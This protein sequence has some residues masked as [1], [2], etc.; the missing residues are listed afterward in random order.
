MKIIKNFNG[1]IK[2]ELKSPTANIE[3]KI[4]NKIIPFF[5]KWIEGYHLTLMT[6]F[7]SVGIMICSFLYKK[8]I[9]YILFGV[10]IQAGQWF[11]DSFDG[12]LGKY[13]NT[14]IPRWGYYMD[15]FLDFIF[16]CSTIVGFCFIVNPYCVFYMSLML[17]PFAGFFINSFLLFGVTQ[18]FK[19]TFFGLGPTEIRILFSIIYILIY[20]FG[21]DII[22]IYTIMFAFISLMLGLFITVYIAQKS[23]WAIDMEEKNKIS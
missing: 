16:G 23:I 7:W 18:E 13:R 12:S 15:H 1:D 20:K 8:N 5:P 17:I 10:L 2:A 21:A 14:G 9:Y 11:T 22:N 19:I 3:K 6:I 4:I